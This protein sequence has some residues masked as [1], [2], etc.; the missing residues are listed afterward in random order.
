MPFFA[1]LRA[2]TAKKR[3]FLE[4]ANLTESYR[5]LQ[6]RTENIYLTESYRKN[7]LTKSLQDLTE[8]TFLT[9]SLQNLTENI[10]FNEITRSGR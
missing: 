1:V 9:K 2:K 3:H 8:N 10:F 7:F 5:I 4:P 6:N